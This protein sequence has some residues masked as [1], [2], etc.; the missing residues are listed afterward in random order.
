MGFY[1]FIIS[2]RMLQNYYKKLTST[3]HQCLQDKHSATD[4][5]TDMA[6]SSVTTM[7]LWWRIKNRPTR[8]PK[9][10]YST[11]PHPKWTGTRY[12]HPT[13]IWTGTRFSHPT[14]KRGAGSSDFH[15]KEYSPSVTPSYKPT[16]NI[17][18]WW[19]G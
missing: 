8:S 5:T 13:V 9:Q 6:W 1:N 10:S 19:Q 11:Y 12:P 17:P 3:Y 16:R 15:T 2:Y 4:T 14:W 7:P 18:G